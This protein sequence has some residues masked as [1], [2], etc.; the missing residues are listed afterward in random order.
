MASEREFCGQSAVAIGDVATYVWRDSYE[1]SC[2]R[3]RSACDWEDLWGRLSNPADTLET[4][5]EQGFL[6]ESAAG[7]TPQKAPQRSANSPGADDP[8]NRGQ[9]S[10][11]ASRALRAD[12]ER[13]HSPTAGRAARRQTKPV[14]RRLTSSEVAALAAEYHQGR[15]LRC[16]S[17][18]L[19]QIVHGF[20]ESVA[21]LSG[22]LIHATVGMVGGVGTLRTKRCLLYTS[23]AADEEDS[24]D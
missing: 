20:S 15:S 6:A 9:H 4:V 23:D 19:R 14:Q 21:S 10:N 22:W 11:P 8:N 13:P 24:V 2:L 12:V 16:L 7:R 18:F 3:Q 1:H 17:T 5:P